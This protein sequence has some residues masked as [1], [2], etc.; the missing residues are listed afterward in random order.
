MAA[1]AQRAFLDAAVLALGSR[2]SGLAGR[3]GE[4]GA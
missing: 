4:A 2:H 1:V 3:L